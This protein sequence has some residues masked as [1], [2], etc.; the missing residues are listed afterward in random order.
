MEP[1]GAA[2]PWPG[3]RWQSLPRLHVVANPKRGMGAPANARQEST[4]NDEGRD[5]F[6]IPTEM[7]SMAES[8]VGQARKGFDNFVATAQQMAGNIEERG[9]SVRAGARDISAKAI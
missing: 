3:F 1:A 2:Q 6:Q 8:S 7:R 4:M 5:R 9:A